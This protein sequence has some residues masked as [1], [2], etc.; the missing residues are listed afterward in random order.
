[1]LNTICVKEFRP[2]QSFHRSTEEEET[3]ERSGIMG[4]PQELTTTLT[5]NTWFWVMAWSLLSCKLNLNTMQLSEFCW[6]LKHNVSC[7]SVHSFITNDSLI[8]FP[9]LYNDVLKIRQSCVYSAAK[10]CDMTG[11]K[12]IVWYSFIWHY[13]LNWKQ[14]RTAYFVIRKSW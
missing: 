8:Y 2:L 13:K 12:N 6:I 10:G 9:K 1:M 3:L 7:Y 14:S 4:A 5:L 11:K